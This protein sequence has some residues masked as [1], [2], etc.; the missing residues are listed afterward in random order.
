MDVVLP[1]GM[2]IVG[3]SLSSRAGQSHKLYS[4]TQQ[5]GSV[6]ILA[7]SIS[8]ETFSG[9]EGAVLYID[10]EGANASSVEILNILFSDVNANTRAFKLGNNVTGID[11][12]GS[13]FDALKQKVYDLG[14]RVMNGVKKGINIIRNADGS[15][16][17]VAE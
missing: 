1:D 11:A 12:I 2:K 5:D 6:R 8:G 10:V 14:G 13:T 7:S 9:N 3:T 17:K 4:R 16:R 15:T